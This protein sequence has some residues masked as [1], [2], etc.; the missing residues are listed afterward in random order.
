MEERHCDTCKHETLP[1]GIEP[2][3]HCIDYKNWEPKGSAPEAPAVGIDPGAPEGDTTN[4]QRV[5]PLDGREI[6]IPKVWIDDTESGPVLAVTRMRLETVIG[7]AIDGIKE[8]ASKIGLLLTDTTLGEHELFDLTH[9]LANL[10]ER[11]VQLE[12]ELAA[13]RE[14]AEHVKD[15]DA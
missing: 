3:C 11:W 10:H 9:D 5:W 2:C 15:R 4:T 1:S 14:A 13:I 12:T 6:F 8:H 7:Y